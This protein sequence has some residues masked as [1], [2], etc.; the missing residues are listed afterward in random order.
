[1]ARNSGAVQGVFL[2]QGVL[3][4]FSQDIGWGW[5]ICSKMAPSC[6]WWGGVGCQLE[7]SAPL[8]RASPVGLLECPHNMAVVAFPQGK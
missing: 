4:S 2:V 1:M 7:A 6:G 8:L 5:R 3:C